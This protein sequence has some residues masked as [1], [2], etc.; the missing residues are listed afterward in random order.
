A[1][2]AAGGGAGAPRRAHR[3]QVAA[4]GPVGRL[5]EAGQL[6]AVDVSRERPFVGRVV[7]VAVDPSRPEVEGDVPEDCAGVVPRLRADRT[8]GE[9][10]HGLVDGDAGGRGEVV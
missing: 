1:S 9:V 7:L 3:R 5:G 8:H 2:A 6:F 4:V 10:V